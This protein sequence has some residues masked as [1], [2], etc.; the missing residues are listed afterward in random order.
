MKIFKDKLVLYNE[1]SSIR[2]LCFVPTMGELHNGHKSL[3]EKAK[4]YGKKVKVCKG[5][6]AAK[7]LSP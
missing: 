7:S 1:I 6:S 5:Q 3:I 2:N 4:R